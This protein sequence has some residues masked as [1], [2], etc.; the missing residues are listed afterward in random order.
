MGSLR[1]KVPYPR[2]NFLL[3]AC[4]FIAVVKVTVN[5]KVLPTHTLFHLFAKVFFANSLFCPFA[6]VFHHQSFPLYGTNYEHKQQQVH[7]LY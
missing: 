2:D 1:K 3:S 6:K 7:Q 4:Q 5:L